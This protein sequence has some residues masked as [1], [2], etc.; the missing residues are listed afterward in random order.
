MSNEVTTSTARA[1]TSRINGERSAGPVSSEGKTVAAMNGV[2]HGLASRSVLLPS[3]TTTDYEANVNA[4]VTTLQPSSPGE[5]EM[6]TRVADL[7][8]RIRRLQ[9]LEDKHLTASLEA[10]LKD[11]GIFGML[12]IAQN[13]SLG[14]S[15][16][17]ATVADIK[18]ACSGERLGKLLSPIGAVM[19]IVEAADLPM[20]VI[21]PMGNVLAELKAQADAE[22]VPVE[23]FTRL[24]EIGNKVIEA[25]DSK[26]AD[27]QAKVVVERERIA[28]DLLLGD[29]KE[30]K[31]FERHRAAINKSLDSELARMKVVRELSQGTVGSSVGPIL[32]E[33]KL[34]GRR[35]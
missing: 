21:V 9:R 12:G 11:S 3:E 35:E 1:N 2:Q 16:M 24:V 13:A 8:F 18:A 17:I 25:L 29:D 6:V 30:L 20:A 4:W 14:M 33:L 31:K 15:A 10:K 28:D 32:I 19:D 23:P 5:G 7:N 22:L 26:I 34:I 27:L